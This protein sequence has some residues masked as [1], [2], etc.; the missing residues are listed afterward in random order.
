MRQFKLHQQISMVDVIFVG[1]DH[2]MIVS[3]QKSLTLI[4][5][6]EFLFKHIFG[7]AVI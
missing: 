7:S 3:Q 5:W 6:L 4:S 2:L 1:F